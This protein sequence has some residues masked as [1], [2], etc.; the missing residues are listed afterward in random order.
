MGGHKLDSTG[1][2]KFLS[3]VKGLSIKL[4]MIVAKHL[5]LSTMTAAVC[6]AFCCAKNIEEKIWVEC[7]PQF[8]DRNWQRVV[9]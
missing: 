5:G 1:V 2:N 8:N 3:T 4:M 6:N 9:I 7:G